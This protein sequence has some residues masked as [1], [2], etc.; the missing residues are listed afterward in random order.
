MTNEKKLVVTL[1]A[2]KGK[3][4]EETKQCISSHDGSIVFLPREVSAGDIVRVELSP[5]SEKKDARGKVMYS[6]KHAPI[7]ISG[8]VRRLIAR[9]AS[10]LRGCQVFDQQTGLALL[11]TKYGIELDAWKE[12]PH[13]YFEES[14]WVFGSHFSSATLYL[15]EQFG[16][17]APHATTEPILWALDR[18]FFA[19][20]EQGKELDWRSTIPQITDEAVAELVKRVQVGEPVLSTALVKIVGGRIEVPAL[21]DALWRLATW[22]TPLVPDFESETSAVLPPVVSHE[23]GR[24]P[25]GEILKGYAILVLSADGRAA[26]KWHKDFIEASIAH[27]ASEMELVRLREVWNEKIR[28]LQH[29]DPWVARW[30][31]A[32]LPDMRF[33]STTFRVE[34]KSYPYSLES[35]SEVERILREKE[36]QLALRELKK[37]A[38]TLSEKLKVL[39]E[40]FRVPYSREGWVDR[41]EAEVRK[42]LFDEQTSSYVPSERDSVAG[43]TEQVEQ[44]VADVE[45][46]TSGYEEREVALEAAKERGE[47]LRNF[48]AYVRRSGSS[49]GD[50]WV[51]KPDGSLREPGEVDHAHPSGFHYS[52]KIW[53]VVKAD[54][55]G[56]TWGDG[57]V[58][59]V[60]HRAPGYAPTSAQLAK[61]REIEQEVGLAP[62][63]FGLDP[64]A[65]ERFAKLL[66]DV[67]RACASSRVLSSIPE[68]DIFTVIRENG[69][70]VH[71]E[72][73][74]GRNPGDFVSHSRPFD[75]TCS[76]REAQTVETKPVGT[77]GIL[78]F[79]V[80][81]KYGQ[82]NLN[83]RYRARRDDDLEK[84][85]LEEPGHDSWAEQLAA[86]RKKFS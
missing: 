2:E 68:L 78:E 74:R 52:H 49:Q 11:R 17:M 3:K 85:T 18:R 38:E 75:A 55:L 51:I 20:R 59:A 39:R 60:V 37:K 35:V 86:L 30:A 19:L 5:V 69:Q 42:R 41:L 65:T 4:W 61:V 33:E 34:W 8:N 63:A 1:L 15:Y 56:L 14:G 12:Y 67:R 40:E 77:K 22:P 28:V 13:Y 48:R 27:E 29:L 9:E 82:W 64:E 79:L 62:G 26:W 50:G 46:S 21:T 72:Y 57:T 80:Y 47:I 6:A 7:I 23:Y 70:E 10:L 81:D 44:L 66:E 36:E 76:N 32:G 24:D 84:R 54:E 25:N 58:C 71:E 43:W 73:V 83:V 16:M 53:R 31:T 45:K